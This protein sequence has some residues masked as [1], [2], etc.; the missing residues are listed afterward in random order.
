MSLNSEHQIFKILVAIGHNY[1]G[2]IRGRHNNFKDYM[3][4]FLVKVVAAEMN[5]LEWQ[6]VIVKAFVKVSGI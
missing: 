1:G 4:D 5:W 2:N 6:Q 3:L